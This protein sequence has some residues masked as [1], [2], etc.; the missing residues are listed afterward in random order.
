MPAPNRSISESSV[1]EEGSSKLKNNKG[2]KNKQGDDPRKEDRGASS[3]KSDRRNS[4]KT[5]NLVA[6]CGGA[7]AVVVVAIVA[8]LSISPKGPQTASALVVD[9]IPCDSLEHTDYHT[10]THLDIFVDGKPQQVP[11]YIG[12]EGPSNCLFWLHTHS[13]DGIIHMEAPQQTKMTLGQLFDIWQKTAND[14]TQFPQPISFGN[15]AGGGQPSVYVNGQ[16]LETQQDYRNTTIYP[17]T[18]MALVYGQPPATIPTSFVFGQ[19][20]LQ[21]AGSDAPLIQRIVTPATAVAGPLG[22]ASAPVTIVEFGDYQCNSCTL[23]YRQTNSAVIANLVDTG[24]AKLLFKDFTLNDYVL[25]PTRGSTLAAEAAYCAGDQGKFWQYHDEL[26]NNQ[27]PEGTVWVSED[28]LKGFAAVVGL[29]LPQFTNCLDSAKYESTVATNNSLVRELSLDATP[30]FIIVPSD[31]KTD[32]V[33]LVGA[34]PYAS[35][36]AVVNQLIAAG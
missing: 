13:T 2:K 20:N 25:Q 23:F 5:R 31:G 17:N 8:I 1:I 12:I 4:R 26:Y 7:G 16:K 15:G 35:F 36:E 34:Y 32:P 3:K 6:I 33:K 18:E 10:H 27:K 24:K 11:A 19:S 29:D 21:N 30:T 14:V 22:N 9:G 28:S